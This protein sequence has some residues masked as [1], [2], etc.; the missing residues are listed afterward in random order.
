[1]KYITS[2]L[3][4]LCAIIGALSGFCF[5][6][7]IQAV[8]FDLEG[9]K[10]YDLHAKMACGSDSM[11]LLLRC[12]ARV[13]G[14]LISRNDNLYLGEIYIYKNKTESIIHRLIACEDNCTRLLFKGDNNAKADV[15]IDREDYEIYY[16]GMIK[17]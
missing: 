1:M 15:W 14:D 16:V 7:G 4:I 6:N 9:I 8:S 10:A 17:Y 12:G 13:Y 2:I 5:S 3:M 11:G